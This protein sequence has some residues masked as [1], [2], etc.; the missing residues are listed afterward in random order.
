MV[1]TKEVS[2]MNT[3]NGTTVRGLL[4]AALLLGA[5]ACE[6]IYG[7]GRAAEEERSVAPFRAVL[8]RAGLRAQISP[9][10]QRVVVTGDDNIVPHVMT[11]VHGSVLTIEPEVDFDPVVPL[12]TI[13]SAPEIDGASLQAG[14]ELT[15]RE[16]D[17]DAFSLYLD[18]GGTI[19]ASG[20]ARQLDVTLTAGGTLDARAVESPSVTVYGAAGGTM[21]VTAREAVSGSI[22]S[23]SQA[24]IYGAP[25]SRNVVTRSGGDVL[26]VE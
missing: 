12:L 13:V 8:V 3:S 7:S 6:T 11:Q 2:N 24:R 19:V 21:L 9:G 20:T 23:G 15:V 16:L 14:G 26:Y 18:A 4:T 5:T 17:A 1:R 25:P 22:E 10:P